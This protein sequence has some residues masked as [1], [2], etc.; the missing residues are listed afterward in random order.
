MPGRIGRRRRCR[1]S[2][3][4]FKTQASHPLVQPVPE[5]V[6]ALSSRA[7][8]VSSHGRGTGEGQSSGV[9]E[10]RCAFSSLGREEIRGTAGHRKNRE[11]KT[12]SLSLW[13]SEEGESDHRLRPEKHAQQDQG[14]WW[15]M[16]EA[17]QGR[18]KAWVPAFT[19]G[20]LKGVLKFS[21]RE[22]GQKDPAG[23]GK[24]LS[25]KVPGG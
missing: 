9:K 22:E 3:P 10:A 2:V 6:P 11:S 7:L 16:G 13:D 14:S 1:A 5:N 20:A 21:I 25:P 24:N 17:S 19:S 8:N 4:A 23:S 12:S 15:V 18:A